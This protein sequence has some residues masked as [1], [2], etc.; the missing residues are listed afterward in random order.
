MHNNLFLLAEE[1]N[2]NKALRLIVKLVPMGSIIDSTLAGFYTKEKERRLK[3]FFDELARY[4]LQLSE[5]VIHSDDFLHKY[6]ITLKAALET[7]RAEKIQYFARLL[8]NSNEPIADNATD[9]YE[10]FLKVLD[11]LTYQELYVLK[12]LRSKEKENKNPAAMPLVYNKRFYRSLKKEL[13]E[14]LNVSIDEVLSIYI[15]LGRTG[16]INLEKGKQ[17][18]VEIDDSIATTDFFKKLELLAIEEDK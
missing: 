7:K 14:E 6:F 13:A 15:R 5:E 8:K 10:D 17:I 3:V 11:D 2:S 1:Y 18:A 9:Y 16:C 12:R 4:D